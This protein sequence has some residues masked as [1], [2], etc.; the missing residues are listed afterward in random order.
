MN[1]L[2]A[3]EQYVRDHLEDR[4]ASRSLIDHHQESLGVD[5]RTAV[6]AVAALRRYELTALYMR[7]AAD[8]L[9]DA[10][11]YRSTLRNDVR[12]ETFLTEE[13]QWTLLLVPG[14]RPP[15]ARGHDWHGDGEHYWYHVV[16]VGSRWIIRTHNWNCLRSAGHNHLFGP[17]APTVAAL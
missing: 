14:W 16:I 7:L 11:P 2:L 3:H 17:T 12:F 5:R 6:K 1:D 15:T 13:H 4:T 9:A 8:L 10:S